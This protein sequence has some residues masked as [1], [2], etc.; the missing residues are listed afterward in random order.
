M[1]NLVGNLGIFLVCLV[2]LVG[3]LGMGGVVHF[4]VFLKAFN[5][6]GVLVFE[7]HD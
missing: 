1:Q 7:F 2:G 6:L 5:V 4:E 3:W